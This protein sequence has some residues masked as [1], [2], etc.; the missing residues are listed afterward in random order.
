MTEKAW[1]YLSVE[2]LPVFIVSEEV[3][4]KHSASSHP[5]PVNAKTAHHNQD[6]IC[7]YFEKLPESISNIVVYYTVPEVSLVHGGSQPVVNTHL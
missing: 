7:N 5:S 6:V 2:A 3:L 1:K 4:T